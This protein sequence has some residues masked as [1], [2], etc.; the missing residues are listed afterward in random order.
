MHGYGDIHKEND[1]KNIYVI[2]VGGKHA[3]QDT[4]G[5]GWGAWAS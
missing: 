4:L 3:P 1:N 2:Y 5:G